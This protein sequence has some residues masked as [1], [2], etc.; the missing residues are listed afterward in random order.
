MEKIRTPIILPRIRDPPHIIKI[1]PTRRP[2]N[3]KI[4]PNAMRNSIPPIN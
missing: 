4:D 1:N 2:A 3:P